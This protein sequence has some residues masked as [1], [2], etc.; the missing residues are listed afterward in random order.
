MSKASWR[1]ASSPRASATEA[2]ASRATARS[3][4]CPASRAKAR[5]KSRSPTAVARSRPER[6]RDG[7]LAA[8]QGRIVEDVVVDQRRHVDELDRGGRAH[9]RLSRHR[10]RRRAG[11]AADAGACLPRPGSPSASA[12]EQLAVPAALLAQQLLDLAQPRRQPAARGVED[13]GDRRRNGRAAGHPRTPLWIA[14]IPPASTVQRIRSSPAAS[15]ISAR[16]GGRG[17]AA[18]RLGQVGVGL[19][20]ARRARRAAA[21]SGRTRARRRSRAAVGSAG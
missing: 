19:G 5:E 16:R 11:P 10:R 7:R 20:L 14:M 9:R 3:S 21:R 4:P 13:R 15:I 8:A 2:S 17:E 6:C 12:A 1:W 18:H